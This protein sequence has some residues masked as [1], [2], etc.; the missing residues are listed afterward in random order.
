[1]TKPKIAVVGAGVAGLT[2]AWKLQHVAEVTLYE[3]NDYIGGHTRTLKIP[4]GPDAGTAVDTGFIVM[5]HRNYPHFTDLLKEWQVYLE[6]SDMS[7]SYHE[8]DGGYEYAGTDFKG[9]FPSVKYLTNKE[10][11]KLLREIRRFG[12]LGT[13]AL[14]HHSGNK[15]TLGEFLEEHHFSDIFRDRYLYAM[16]AAIWSSPP[17]RLASF[18]AEPYLH[19]FANHGLLTL[20]D[21]P[22]WRIISGGSQSYIQKALS[23][24]QAQVHT[25][26]TPNKI[27]RNSEGALLHF[28]DG[29]KEQYD[30]VVI[31]AHADE[32]LRL[33]GDPDAEEKC[34]LGAW[35]YIPNEVILHS[36]EG[37]M[38]ES[39]HCWASWNFTKE[40]DATSSDLVSVTY[41]MNRLQNLKTK[42]NYFVTL[43][44]KGEIPPKHI[45][46]STILHHP[47]YDHKAL[48]TQPYLH[49]RNGSRRTWLVGSYFGYGF[50]EDAVRSAVE[51]TLRLKASL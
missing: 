16:G 23:R 40:H 19:F 27:F 17:S 45:I 10:H 49:E 1:M 51:T 20:K 30:H 42:Q 21:R 33:L 3:K 28:S 39:P 14:E 31:G 34:F 18:P 4:T 22:Q 46:N 50:H 12:E 41:W 6:D 44:H 11:W 24:L 48:A 35:K 5:N 26:L 32:A 43:N 47:F 36:W 37:V 7:F 29:R 2:A 13:H 38:P 25:D 8:E 9:V 15:Q